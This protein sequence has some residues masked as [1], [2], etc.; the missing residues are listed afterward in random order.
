MF[1][2]AEGEAAGRKLPGGSER[3]G[4]CRI[5]PGEILGECAKLLID[6]RK[7]RFV[8]L[9]VLLV[10]HIAAQQSDLFDEIDQQAESLGVHEFTHGFA[11]VALAA[12]NTRDGSACPSLGSMAREAD[13]TRSRFTPV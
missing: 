8:F 2:I 7:S 13:I 6:S 11:R 9:E 5:V 10:L 12:R 3:L 4:Q 1:R